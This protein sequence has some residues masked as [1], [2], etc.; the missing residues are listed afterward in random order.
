MSADRTLA[1]AGNITHVFNPKNATFLFDD[2][3]DGTGNFGD[4][5]WLDDKG[6]QGITGVRS[7]QTEHPGIVYAQSVAG[8]NAVSGGGAD[9]ATIYKGLTAIRTEGSWTWEWDVWFFIEADPVQY[10]HGIYRFGWGDVTNGDFTDGIYIEIDY[11]AHGSTNLFICCAAGGART[12]T[13]T[14][15]AAED[16]TWRRYKAVVN[17]AANSVEFFRD[18]VSL[19]TVNT[20]IPTGV[21][22]QCG[23]IVQN[24]AGDD[25]GGFG[26]PAQ[27]DIEIRADY[28]W[29]YNVAG[30]SR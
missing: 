4:T 16:S 3:I 17:A 1:F 18:D 5:N 9:Y 19:G 28:F 30:I 27:Q 24:I 15:I 12:K 25:G 26:N 8:G 6:T 22:Q 23:P 2:F 21:A 10:P 29:Q 13:D 20:N 7:G 14:G 11:T